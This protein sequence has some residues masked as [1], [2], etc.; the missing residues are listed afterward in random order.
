[1]PRDGRRSRMPWNAVYVGLPRLARPR[2]LPRRVRIRAAAAA[3]IRALSNEPE[4]PAR[5]FPHWAGLQVPGLRRA[6]PLLF[7][8]D[9]LPARGPAPVT[10]RRSLW[11][12]AA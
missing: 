11:L 5:S 3:P 2:H 10:A 1:M 9:L 7:H 12:V 8:D 4:L 6:R